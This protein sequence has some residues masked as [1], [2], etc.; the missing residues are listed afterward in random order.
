MIMI[1]TFYL[2]FRIEQLFLMLVIHIK[3]FYFHVLS[4]EMKF[5]RFFNFFTKRTKA[6][7]IFRNQ[8][9]L[10]MLRQEKLNTVN[11]KIKLSYKQLN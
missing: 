3:V 11:K 4:F 9:K 2:H 5:F 8:I 7:M 6:I 10:L 1:P